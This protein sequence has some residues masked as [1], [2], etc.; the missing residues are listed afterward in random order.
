VLHEGISLAQI[1]SGSSIPAGQGLLTP[2][3][4]DVILVLTSQAALRAILAINWRLVVIAINIIHGKSINLRN[5][6]P[7]TLSLG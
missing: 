2:K 7:I 4:R 1:R 3:W 6:L 5:L